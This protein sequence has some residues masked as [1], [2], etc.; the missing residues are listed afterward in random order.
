MIQAKA[1]NTKSAKRALVRGWGRLEKK[2]GLQPGDSLPARKNRKKKHPPLTEAQQKLVSDHMW[3]AGRLAHSARAMTGGF[4]G[5]FTRDD[6]ESVAFFALCVAATRYDE[7]LGWQFSTFAWNTAR[8][9]IQHALRDHSRMVRVP[10][11]IMP[12]REEVKRM[13]AEGATYEEVCEEL[14]LT[15]QQVLM[16]E[17]SWQEI[18]SSYDH[19]PDEHRPRE[20][21]YEI[22]EAKTLVGKE[23][24]IALGDLP[25]ADLNLLLSHVEG[26]LEDPSEVKRAEELMVFLKSLVSKNG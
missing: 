13:L 24:M 14:G 1:A 19:T 16:C 26:E 7:S 18:H 10:R 25:D 21:I 3:I 15:E 17:Q 20:F 2:F 12:V 4:T 8:G 11:W 5:C 9:Y 6:L 22:D 23:V